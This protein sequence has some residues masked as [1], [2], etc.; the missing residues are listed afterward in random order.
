MTGAFVVMAPLENSM[1]EGVVIGDI[2]AALIGQDACFDLPVGEA[3][4]EG[5]RDIIVHGLEG[6]EN[7]GV[8]CRG[9]LDVM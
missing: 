2:D 1:T 6:L 4:T 5:K 3:G 9:G 7:E 8:A